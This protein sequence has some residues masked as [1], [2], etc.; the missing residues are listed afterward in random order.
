MLSM[1]LQLD[2][3]IINKS[4]VLFWVSTCASPWIPYGPVHGIHVE[5]V[6]RVHGIHNKYTL[7]HME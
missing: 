6:H 3:N 1:T 7:V 5:P 2:T 4:S